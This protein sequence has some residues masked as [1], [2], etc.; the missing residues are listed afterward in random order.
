MPK[1]SEDVHRIVAEIERM[2]ATEKMVALHTAG[3]EH[4][5]A[6]HR[7]DALNK[8]LDFIRLRLRPL[9]SPPE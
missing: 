1:L 5:G 2:I 9:P 6:R 7:I 4:A 8:V 3:D